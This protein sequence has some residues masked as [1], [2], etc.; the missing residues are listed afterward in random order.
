MSYL[1]FEQASQSPCEGC[2]APCCTFLPL[3]DF[4]I[5]HLD[6]LDYALYLVN[7]ANIELALVNGT[8]WRVHYRQR[9]S[10]LM[11][12]GGCQLHGQP[13]KPLVCQNYSA[14]SCF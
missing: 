2:A 11:P 12:N 9:C 3:H 7:F 14:T 5:Q 4:V 10:R 8:T 13:Q 1:S 6:H